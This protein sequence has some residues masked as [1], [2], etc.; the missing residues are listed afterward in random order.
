VWT[1]DTANGIEI[2]VGV[3]EVFFKASLRAFL[4]HAWW[5]G[6]PV[7]C[8][9]K[10]TSWQHSDFP[11]EYRLGPCKSHS[12]CWPAPV[13]AKNTLGLAHV[14]GQWLQQLINLVRSLLRVQK[15]RAPPSLTWALAR[16]GAAEKRRF[17]ETKRKIRRKWHHYFNT[18]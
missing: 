11:W 15:V 12:Q 6:L 18:L 2:F 17:S 1:N 10:T 14:L 13:S 3:I 7:V 9:P 8:S 16:L 4:F 5:R